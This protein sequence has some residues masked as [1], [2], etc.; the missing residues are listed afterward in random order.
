VIGVYPAPLLNSLEA[1][2]DQVTAHVQTVQAA[3]SA[4]VPLWMEQAR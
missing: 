4:Q 3:P 1:S 2:V